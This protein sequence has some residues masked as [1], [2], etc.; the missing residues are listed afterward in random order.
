MLIQSTKYAFLVANKAA[1]GSAD[2]AA[3]LLKTAIFSPTGGWGWRSGQRPIR[4]V[5]RWKIHENK[6]SGVMVFSRGRATLKDCEL[7]G[8]DR[9]NVDIRDGCQVHRTGDLER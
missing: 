7:W 1:C 4:W 9:N 6:E 3:A 2:T 8:Q 5:R